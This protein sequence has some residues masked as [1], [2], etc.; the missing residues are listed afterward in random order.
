MPTLIRPPDNTDV[1][2]YM[3]LL[4][5]R[6]ERDIINEIKRKRASGYVDYA[7]VAALERIQKILQ[8]LVDESWNYVPKMIEKIFYH[9][10]KDAAGYTNA[11][12]IIGGSLSAAQLSIAEQLSNNLLGE[13]GEAAAGAYESAQKVFTIARL[14]NDPFRKEALQ[15]VLKKEAEGKP[16]ITGSKAFVQ[17]MENQGIPVFVDKR[18]R[19]WSMQDYG[20]MA[21]R[22]TARQAQVAALL[23]ADDY[24]LW[25]IVKIGST[26]PVCAPLEGRV[27][28]KSGTNPDYP[29][30]T[31]AFGKIDPAGSNDLTNTYLNIHPN[32]LHDLVRYTTIGKSAERIQKDKDF[33]SIE[34]NPIS[35][36]P[37][38]KKQVE[39]YR[40]KQRNRQQLYRDMRQ[41]KA[42]RAVL[43][44]DIPK[45]FA[46][47]RD[48]KY[49]DPEKWE[50]TKGLKEYLE[51]YPS[52]NKKYYNVGRDLKKLGMHNIGD[53]L[54]PQKK[55]AFIL[56]EG[57]R[58]PYHI[59][60]RMMERQITDDDIRGYMNNAHCMF[61]QW[62]GK[63][64]VFYSSSGVCVITKSGDD[65]IYKTAWNKTDFD[66][67]TEKILE[68]IRKNGL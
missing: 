28:S 34:K 42:Y 67:S 29:P 56:P 13:I 63:R 58:D 38:T 27:Y 50:Y 14:E 43:G 62:G 10:E 60:H 26:C 20:N 44:K 35:R 41:H 3:R 2:S 11:R 52:S 7:E 65:W 51:K 6:A 31:V 23:T 5:L 9:S 22:T 12:S 32:C 37:R 40:E 30:L 47:F 25:Q 54:S 59:M 18:G 68:V 33:S 16:W 4:F 17:E 19:K 24:D 15:A 61:S 45:D 21:V 48:L 49:N 46:K 64:Q 8:E 1:T 57:N 66:E 36:D 39:A 55:Q 53:P